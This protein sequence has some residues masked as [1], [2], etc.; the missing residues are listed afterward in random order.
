VHNGPYDNPNAIAAVPDIDME[1][2][3]EVLR[4]AA[5][6]RELAG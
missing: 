1:E 4:Q 5:L 2:Q 6:L 3:R